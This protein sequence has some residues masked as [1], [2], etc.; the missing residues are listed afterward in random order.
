MLDQYHVNDARVDGVLAEIKIPFENEKYMH[1]APRSNLVSCKSSEVP[2]RCCRCVSSIPNLQIPW[3][4]FS[5]SE[6]DGM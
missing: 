6:A 4:L 2:G 3:I 1:L 5:N